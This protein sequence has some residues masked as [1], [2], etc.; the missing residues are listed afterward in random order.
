MTTT[1]CWTV[2]GECY[3]F[4]GTDGTVCFTYRR[5]SPKNECLCG[6]NG[7][8][9]DSILTPEYLTSPACDNP[10]DT[11]TINDDYTVEAGCIVIKCGIKEARCLGES[12]S[13]CTECTSS[14]RR[15]VGRQELICGKWEEF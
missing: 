6:V 5:V 2:V 7:L 11:W 9:A 12:S 1:K 4:M 15:R 14:E 13:C 10:D 8:A 3:L